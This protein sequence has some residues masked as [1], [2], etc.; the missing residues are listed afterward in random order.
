M[1][2]PSAVG[3]AGRRDRASG[4]VLPVDDRSERIAKRFE[5][6]VLIA[7]LLVIPVIVIEQSDW[8]ESWKTLAVAVNWLIWLMFFA[9]FATLL[10]VV[11]NKAAWLRRHPLEL[12]IVVL[13]PPFLPASLQALRVFRLA[14]L[15]RLM[16]LAPLARRFFSLEGVR[17]AAVL[18]LV[19]ALGGGAAFAA[20]ERQD[21]STWDGVWWAVSTM[22]TVGY[23]DVYPHT[24]LGRVIA[25]GLMV[26][27]IGFIAI[28]TAALAQRFLTTELREGVDELGD[29]MVAEVEHA[30]ADVLAELRE[31]MNR[32]Q[33]VERQLVERR[34]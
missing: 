18:A 29:E 31:V 6:P 9:E 25:I 13:T 4:E 20:A 3:R 12:A 1:A 30:E 11:P 15:L 5:L 34:T 8:G 7:A 32:L 21:L 2:S 23:G 17:Y 33:A 28:L 27:G 22:T 10:F 14:R 19:T 26:V 24:D 16:R